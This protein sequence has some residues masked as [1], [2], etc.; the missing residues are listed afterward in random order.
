MCYLCLRENPFT[1][2]APPD[3]TERKKQRLRE[4]KQVLSEAADKQKCDTGTGIEEALRQEQ[5]D[6]AKE[7]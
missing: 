4:I 2:I 3:T 6:L 5:Y 1:T 7:L